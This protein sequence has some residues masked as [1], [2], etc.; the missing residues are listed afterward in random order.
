MLFWWPLMPPGAELARLLNCLQPAELLLRDWAGTRLNISL[1]LELAALDYGEDVDEHRQGIEWLLVAARLPEELPYHPG[2]VL[3]LSSW[4]E[5][6]DPERRPGSAGWREHVKRLFSCLIVLRV[7][8]TVQPV[9]SLASLMES[10]LELGPEATQAA[11]RY[12]A[13]CRLHEPGPWRNDVTALPLLTLGLL[14]LH[15][16]SPPGGDGDVVAGL[17][18]AFADEIDAALDE[19]NLSWTEHAVPEL[20]KRTTDGP[21]RRIWRSLAGRCLVDGPASNADLGAQLALLGRAIRGDT[22]A[23]IETLRS[24]FDVPRA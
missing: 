23:S 16:T 24:W 11:I 7:S 14:L 18:R 5:V 12:L 10:A 19:E 15:V 9:G 6:D 21:R 4:R 8:D 2:E 3:S 17:A 22:T 20:L 13:W 1:V